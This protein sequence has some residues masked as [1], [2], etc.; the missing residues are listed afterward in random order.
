MGSPWRNLGD[1]AVTLSKKLVGYLYFELIVCLL[2]LLSLVL[3]GEDVLTPLDSPNRPQLDRLQSILTTV[4]CIELIMRRL[5]LGSWRQFW[6]ECWLDVLAVMSGIRVLRITGALRLLRL[7]RLIRVLKLMSRTSMLRD[8]SRLSRLAESAALVFILWMAVV[9]GTLGLASYEKNS[10]FHLADVIE[11]FWRTMFSFFSTQWVDQF[12]HSLGGK[13]VALF[14]IISGSFFFALITGLTAAILG[15]KLREGGRA[16]DDFLLKQLSDHVIFCGWNSGGLAALREMQCDARFVE[17][18][19][20]ILCD[21]DHVEGLETLPYPNRVKVVHEDFTRVAALQRAHLDHAS[22]AILLNDT[23]RGRTP[24]D[25]DARTVL[26]ALTIEKLS[27]RVQTCCELSNAESEPHLRMGKVDEIIITGDLSGSLLAQA[28]IDA[29]GARILHNL[30]SPT[31][32]CSLRLFP[33]E[34]SWV[35]RTFGELLSD[36]HKA[37]GRLPVA[38]CTSAGQARV[39]E[40]DY[41]IAAG[42]S[43]YAIDGQVQV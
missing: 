31:V 41:R 29:V 30:L 39:N 28:A 42:D 18:D 9:V 25:A 23:H 4:F 1:R 26:A 3:L 15:D 27:T 43:L 8:H 34:E 10:A 36:Y 35:G 2:I 40:G 32:G 21:R 17:R 14:V 5:A 6:K 11:A 38:V 22:V 13:V 7:L 37:T 24:Q 16:L 12:P 20:V 33:L 19:V